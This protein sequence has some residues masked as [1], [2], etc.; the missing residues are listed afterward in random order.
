M[1]GPYIKDGGQV[2]TQI[3]T[4]Y[5]MPKHPSVSTKRELALTGDYDKVQLKELEIYTFQLPKDYVGPKKKLNIKKLN[6][7]STQASE[8]RTYAEDEKY[9][10]ICQNY[11]DEDPFEKKLR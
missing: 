3:S 7:A 8:T 5:K 4:N 6:T 1:G 10:G 11:E 2:G 9:G